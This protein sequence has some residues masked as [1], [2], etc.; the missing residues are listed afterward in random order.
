M[1]VYI[2]LAVSIVFGLLGYVLSILALCKIAKLEKEI[3]L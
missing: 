2:L 1:I 3:D